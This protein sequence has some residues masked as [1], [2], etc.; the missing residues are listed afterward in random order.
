MTRNPTPL[1]PWAT[2]A[3]FLLVGTTRADWPA[4]RGPHGIGV[5]GERDGAPLPARLGDQANLIWKSKL[6]GPGASTPII[7][8]DRVFVTC[9]SGYGAGKDDTELASLRRQLV[10]LDRKTGGVLWH[11]DVAA[12]LP[13]TEYTGQL[14]QHGYATSSPATDGERVY[15]FF[16]RTGVLAFDF[17]GK[18]LWHT[19][20]GKGLSNW[21][22]ASSPLLFRGLVVV[23]ATVECGALVALDRVTGK[24]AWRTKVTGDSWATPVLVELPGGKQEIVLNAHGTLIGFDPTRG[25]ELWQCDTTAATAASSTPVVR[26]GIVYVMGGGFGEHLVQAVRAGGRGDVTGSHVVWKQTKVGASNCSPVLVGPHLYLYSGQACCLRADTGEVVYQERLAGLGPEY[27]S[28]VVADGKLFLFT[29]RG[30]GHVLATGPRFEQ[31][32]RIDLGATGGFTASPAVSHGQL[33][34]RSGDHLYCLGEKK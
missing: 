33:F 1:V 26:D 16:G 9:Y 19:E 5:S 8:G 18:Q 24:E 31:L 27:A 22:S 10:C 2:W 4:F 12:R 15:V 20:L 29:R 21:G 11:R 7:W 32:A 6:P 13:E 25:Q 23:S 3:L 34:V 17:A 28:P 14:R 30:S